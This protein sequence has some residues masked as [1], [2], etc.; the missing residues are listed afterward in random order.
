MKKFYLVIT[1]FFPEPGLF[2]GPFVLDQVKAIE[3]NSDFK[4][5]VMKPQT[6]GHKL[7]DYEYDGIKVYRFKDYTLP[8][9]VW[10]CYFI[11]S[12]SERSMLKKLVSLQIDLNEIKTCHTHTTHLGH[13]A[14]AIKKRNPNCQAVLQHH[15]FDVMDAL[16]TMV[17][18]KNIA[19]NM[20][21]GFVIKWIL[22]SVS[23]NKHLRIYIA[24]RV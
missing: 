11:D 24:T 1:P 10:P 12:M 22:I 9:N 18:T 8:S 7:E 16:L 23:A 15:G 2:R 3:R 17:G 5:I 14:L 13:Y 19:L 21:S 20:E 4:V 6:V